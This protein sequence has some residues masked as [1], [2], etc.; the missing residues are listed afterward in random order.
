MTEE[1]PKRL[2]GTVKYKRDYTIVDC[3]NYYKSTVKNPMSKATYRLFFNTLFKEL[4]RQAIYEALIIEMPDNIGNVG[5]ILSK[6][7]FDKTGKRPNIDFKATYEYWQNNPGSRERKVK[8]YHNNM[9]INYMKPVFVWNK[10]KSHRPVKNRN[11]YGFLPIRKNKRRPV[12]LIRAKTKNIT[13]YETF[14]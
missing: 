14:N 11:F 10:Y 4:M 1:L 8:I 13:Y 6:R 3:F 12:Q 2:S 7:Q 9:E 5:V